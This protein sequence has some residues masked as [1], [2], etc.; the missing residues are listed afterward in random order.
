VKLTLT[1]AS[2]S[3]IDTPTKKIKEKDRTESLIEKETLSF[4]NKATITSSKKRKRKFKS[5]GVIETHDDY[6]LVNNKNN[7]NNNHNNNTRDGDDVGDHDDEDDDED[8]NEYH[9]E[10]ITN[11]R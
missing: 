2:S 7:N 6:D 10:D 3:T 8:E 4:S 9:V 1:K 5:R 11:R